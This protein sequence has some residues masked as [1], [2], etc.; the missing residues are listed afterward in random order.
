M[1][2]LDPR[3]IEKSRSVADQRTT[4]EDQLGNRLQPAFVDRP[5]AVTDALAALERAADRG[6]CLEALELVERREMRILVAEMHDESHR[7]QIV[8]QVI[9]EGAASGPGVERPALR[10]DHSAGLMFL[11]RNVP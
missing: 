1:H 7:D 6:M 11:G 9:D 2:A 3:H 8:L 5:S 10:V 4:G